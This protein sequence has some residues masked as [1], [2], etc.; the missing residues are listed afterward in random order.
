MVKCQICRKTPNKKKKYTE[1]LI[2]CPCG[3]CDI[4]MHERKHQKTPMKDE[5]NP[6][7]EVLRNYI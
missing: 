5:C 3:N 2:K 6:F 4:F 7:I 1:Y